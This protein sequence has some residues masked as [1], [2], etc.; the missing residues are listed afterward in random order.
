[1]TN[2]ECVDGS[3]LPWHVSNKYYSAEVHFFLQSSVKAALDAMKSYEALVVLCNLCRVSMA[4]QQYSYTEGL[5]F[6]ADS[7]LNGIGTVYCV[8]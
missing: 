6:A 7:K 8:T 1:M 2:A 3:R 4:L 5:I